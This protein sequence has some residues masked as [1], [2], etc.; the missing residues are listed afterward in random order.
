VTSAD[1]VT[2]TPDDQPSYPD[3]AGPLARELITLQINGEVGEVER[4]VSRI[5]MGDEHP[6]TVKHLLIVL[7]EALAHTWS[8]PEEWA[9]QML[10]IETERSDD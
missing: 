4:R 8:G 5:M 7:V 3:R 9:A 10:E 1:P 6:L 2:P